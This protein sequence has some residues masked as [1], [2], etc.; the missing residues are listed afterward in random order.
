MKSIIKTIGVVVLAALVASCSG[1]EKNREHAGMKKAPAIQGVNFVYVPATTFPFNAVPTTLRTIEGSDGQFQV[2]QTGF[3]ISD[4]PVS[5]SMYETVMGEGTWPDAGVSYDDAQHFLDK[6][7]LKTH[8]PVVLPTE[9]MYEA[10]LLCEA[11]QPETYWNELVSDRWGEQKPTALPEKNWRVTEGGNSMVVARRP[12]KREATQRFRRRQGNVFHICIREAGASLKD[13]EVLN[14]P[15]D[16]PAPELSDGKDEVFEIDGVRFTM[17]AV[18]GGALILGATEEQGKYAEDDESPLREVNLR[19][20]KI[21]ETEVTRALWD[22]VMGSLPAGNNL[23]QPEVPVGGINWYDA[24]RFARRLSEL[25]GRPFRIPSENEWEYAARG[26]QSSKHFIFSGSN[27]SS[28]VGSCIYKEDKGKLCSVKS[29]QPNELGIYDMSGNVWEWVRGTMPDGSTLLRG[30]SY[31]SKNTACR[32]SNRQ[33]M[34]PDV[35]KNTFGLRL[36]L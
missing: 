31:N 4:E 24:Q 10:A 15:N 17:K 32:V 36:A 23:S 19:S 34:T 33:G 6:L 29:F 5:P 30:G 28:E 20:F 27:V 35:R 3:W 26:G 18:P 12:F 11:F 14:D 2:V 7:Y 13:L 16:I 1:W 8:F 22:A 9:A 25:T 21:G